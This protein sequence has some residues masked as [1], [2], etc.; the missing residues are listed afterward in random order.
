MKTRNGTVTR[1][2]VLM[3]IANALLDYT[4]RIQVSPSMFQA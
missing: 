2:T 1:D 4:N 3:I